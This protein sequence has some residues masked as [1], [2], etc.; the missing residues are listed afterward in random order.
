MKV[1]FTVK[2]FQQFPQN[3]PNWRPYLSVSKNAGT[4]LL[5]GTGLPNYSPLFSGCTDVGF[6]PRHCS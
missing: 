5:D 2:D 1:G 4:E 6:P 3:V